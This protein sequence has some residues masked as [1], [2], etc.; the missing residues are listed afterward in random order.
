[1]REREISNGFEVCNTRGIVV[2]TFDSA[3]LAFA[4]IVECG[5]DRG[6]LF[7]EEVTTTVRR[8]RVS[9]LRRTA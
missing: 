6:P 4:F 2:A 5:G 7:V 9:W 1:M 8:R 3:D